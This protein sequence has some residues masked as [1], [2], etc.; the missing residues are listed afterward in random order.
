[1]N[2]STSQL[3]IAQESRAVA[4]LEVSMLL[5]EIEASR[6]MLKVCEVDMHKHEIDSAQ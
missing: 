3:T 2:Q 5:E 6:S 4:V 1:M